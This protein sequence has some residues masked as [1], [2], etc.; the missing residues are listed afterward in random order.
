LKDISKEH[1]LPCCDPV[2]TG[3]SDIVDILETV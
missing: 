1:G 3:L 2:R